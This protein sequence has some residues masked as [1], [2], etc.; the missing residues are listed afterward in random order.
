MSNAVKPGFFLINTLHDPPGCFRNMRPF[1][2]HFFRLGIILPTLTAFQIHGAQL[3][4]LKWVVD[5]RQKTRFL[6]LIGDREPIFDDL[7]PTACQHFFELW[8]AAEKLF[9]L[10]VTT[11]AH[12]FFYPGAVV[13]TAVKQH[14]FSCRRQMRYVALEIPLSTLTIVRCR[15]RRNPASAWIQALS[16]P[17]D[18]AT[19]TSGV[20]AFKHNDQSMT[21]SHDPVL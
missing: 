6:F 5:A 9:I 18:H 12:H 8:H 14:H 1:Q 15:Q 16:D 2:H 7:N 4:L 17:L 10:S 19:F 21:G 11:K 13:P 20:T 3:P